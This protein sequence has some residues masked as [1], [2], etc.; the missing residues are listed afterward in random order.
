MK[1]RRINDGVVLLYGRDLGRV[2]RHLRGGGTPS[3]IMVSDMGC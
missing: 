3:V 2:Q 1:V